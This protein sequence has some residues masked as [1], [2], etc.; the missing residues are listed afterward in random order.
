MTHA[1]PESDV[2]TEPKPYRCITELR[3]EGPV[4]DYKVRLQDAISAL[5][6]SDTRTLIVR[7]QTT[8][9]P[10]LLWAIHCE[11]DGRDIPPGLR[12]PANE[13]TP[14][15]DYITWLADLLWFTGRNREHEIKFNG[16]R[17]VFKHEPDSSAWHATA[18]RQ[19]LY[20]EPRYSVAHMCA[21]GLALSD[22]QRQDLMTLPTKTMAASRRQ[23]QPARFAEI[24]ERI[25]AHAI[26]RPDRAGVVKP[27]AVA[28]RR[29]QLWRLF[30][31]SGQNQTA[32]AARWSTLTGE[33]TLTRQAVA[34]QL[35]TV[36][37]VLGVRKPKQPRLRCL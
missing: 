34:K 31:L 4:S 36:A 1:R 17:G 33:D 32:T 16:W 10:L 15:A 35:S 19:F 28:E 25:L 14:Q 9:R 8:D 29:A 22:A 37:D 23:L 6:A 2:T 18:F 30:I 11:L 26:S 20:V 13:E 12:W 27:E 7:L 24:R 5:P 3:A 21:K